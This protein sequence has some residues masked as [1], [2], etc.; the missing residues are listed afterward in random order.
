M[1]ES[2]N[3]DWT[4]NTWSIIK[5]AFENDNFLVTHQIESYNNLIDDTIPRIIEHHMPLTTTKE[6]TDQTIS[7][8]F[9]ILRTY[10]S[11]PLYY[12]GEYTP[13]Y[14][15]KAR[16]C[17]LTYA[18][19]VFIDYKQTIR[20]ANSEPI[21]HIERKVPICELPVMLG[22][23]Y[24]HLYKMS[25]EQR[26]AVNECI[27]DKGGYFIVNGN[28]KVI[29]GQERPHDNNVMCYKESTSSNKR[30]IA[31]AEVKSTIDQ[32]FH[33]IKIATVKLF[34]KED[35]IPGLQLKVGL[36][37]IKQSIPLFIVFRALGIIS[38]KEIFAHLLENDFDDN[39]MVN[40]I[41]PS[42]KISNITTQID[43]INYISKFITYKQP[44]KFA[45]GSNEEKKKEELE[46]QKKQYAKDLINREFLPHIGRDNLRKAHFLAYM[47]RKLLKCQF[48]ETLYSDRDH[49]SN[50]RVDTV[51]PLLA[52]IFRYNF[53]K[54]IR[55][56]KTA[57]IKSLD[58]DN[59]INF[60]VRKYIQ[61]CNI[62]SKIKYALSTGNWHT[63][64]AKA[65]SASK[66]GIAQILQRLS[67]L[68]YLSHMRRLNSPL[69]RM[70]SKFEP[71]RRLHTTQIAKCC[72]L[73]TPE[74]AQVGIV[75][76]MA[77]LCHITVQVNDVPVRY[78]LSKITKSDGSDELAVKSICSCHPSQ[79]KTST[80]VFVNGDLLGLI[81]EA[82]ETEYVYQTLK[83]MKRLAQL[84]S[85]ISIAWFQYKKELVIQVDGGRYCHP[86]Y[87]LNE[88]NQFEINKHSRED[89]NSKS[90]SDLVNDGSIE[91]LDTNEDETS[92][93]AIFPYQLIPG[94]IHP[95]KRGVVVAK[96][97]HDVDNYIN[98][99]SE[100]GSLLGP[101]EAH[102]LIGEKLTNKI[103]K[104]W[105]EYCNI[106]QVN[107][108]T[109]VTIKVP[110]N[111]KKSLQNNVNFVATHIN[112]LYYPEYERFTHFEMHPQMWHGVVAHSIPYCDHNPS[113][114]NCYQCLDK[115]E[116]VL[117]HDG[118]FKKIGDIRVGDK[119]ISVDPKTMK[120]K[121]TNVI[122]QYVK[123]TEKDI[124]K[125]STITKRNLVCTFDHPILTIKNGKTEPEWIPAI[126]LTS[127]DK[128]AVCPEQNSKNITVNEFLK[129]QQSIDNSISFEDWSDLVIAKENSIFVPVR[130]VI[131]HKN[132][133]ISDITVDSEV[134]S[135]I[136]GNRICVH[137]SSMGKQSM[138]LYV[139]NSNVRLDTMANLLCYPQHSL[140]Q[141]RTTEFTNEDKLPHGIQATIAFITYSGYNQEDSIIVSK[142]AIERGFGN[143]TFSRTY[144]SVQQKH[145]SSN[146]EQE[147]FGIPPKNTNARKIGSG[148]ER[149]A[150]LDPETGFP[151]I[152]KY[153]KGNDVLIGKYNRS[154]EKKGDKSSSSDRSTTVRSTERG[155][156]DYVVPNA[157]FKSHL[158]ADGN[159]FCKAR[160]T[161]L[162]QPV[163]GD[164]FSSKHAQKGTIGMVYRDIDMPMTD[165]GIV[166]DVIM[167]PHAIPSRMTVGQMIE[168][169][170]GKVATAEG[171]IQD[172]TAFTDFSIDSIKKRL[173]DYGFDYNGDQVMYNGQTGEM[174]RVPIFI[175]PTYYQ[176]LKH[177][178]ADK[179]HARDRG[180][181]Q[182]MSRQPAEGRSRDGGLRIG[183]MERDCYIAYGASCALKEKMTESSD[184][185]EVWA[186]KKTGTV[187]S[188]NPDTGVYVRGDQDIYGKE[189][190]DKLIYPYSANLLINEL[191]TALIKT[192]IITDE[193]TA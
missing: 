172:A 164:K 20:K 170:L 185:F 114:R 130:N 6:V 150:A 17:N 84:S 39:G 24:C 23:K 169:L 78:V 53:T 96:I 13:L 27:Y 99:K 141:P 3:F 46:K 69:E 126:E 149:Y 7:S 177:M 142:S 56:L 119:V 41:L 112:Q 62:T 82:S 154:K 104:I 135:F 117:M 80:M 176:R 125:V 18:A 76:N 9:K 145:N 49:Y 44:A 34:P 48:D 42:S 160:V 129:Y 55:D 85:Y 45:A 152:G 115:N 19:P 136:T 37:Y 98:F 83:K 52:Q 157:N 21:I 4:Q 108:F 122:N 73:E 186:S 22:S 133:E 174:F 97:G 132:V 190:V 59:A 105:D 153:V 16:I 188:V 90:W 124:V 179:I 29:V 88:G 93:I 147:I 71:P 47:T 161:E 75:K 70:G 182:Q 32:R 65:G 28:E 184:I 30:Y 74:G 134:H 113:T 100:D 61:K 57:F 25:K 72:P 67:Y 163:I 106:I 183:E 193:P 123:Q 10:F 111:L 8:E 173:A 54:L 178:V 131:D 155:I 116:T 11:K 144:I 86:V 191:R 33:P 79:L 121:I 66:K 110:T 118:S 128:I 107:S 171:K 187:V 95:I 109:T 181:V 15:H 81:E 31:R 167:N 38:D 138:G 60:S 40:L 165:S 137:N 148:N 146:V 139:T 43:A 192:H 120:R 143:S 168:A 91:Y 127:K 5:K 35:P 26:M 64:P 77:M 94:M 159:Q 51:G 50:K 14:P 189:Q 1:S 87:V 158:N 102:N 175:N 58:S 151:I 140:V 156:I 162:R 101:E 36:P 92:L 2:K 12:T 63:T 89:L 166:P 68:G 180:P 103:K